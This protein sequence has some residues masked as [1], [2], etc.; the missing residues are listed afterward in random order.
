MGKQFEASTDLGL[1]AEILSYSNTRGIFAG[2]SAE[3]GTLQIDWRANTHYYGQPVAP[4]AILAINSKLAVPELTISLQ[5]MLAEK[6]AWPE[7]IVRGKRI[8]NGT[9]II[10]RGLP[11][12]DDVD[13]IEIDGAIRQQPLPGAAAERRPRLPARRQA[14][15]EAEPSFD[16]ELELDAIPSD[17]KP[18]D[19]SQTEKARARQRRRPARS[20]ARA[21]PSQAQTQ[22]GQQAW[23]PEAQAEACPR[24]QTRSRDRRFTRPRGTSNQWRDP[25]GRLRNANR[26][27][28]KNSWRSIGDQ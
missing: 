20:H 18:K 14:R 10:D 24:N 13:G 28:V 12:D 9:V 26:S 6:T 21:R 11:L 8:R 5:Q 15:P 16:D 1:K 3:G 27:L 17:T 7:R 2:A 4:G 22:A 25:A 19:H 23:D